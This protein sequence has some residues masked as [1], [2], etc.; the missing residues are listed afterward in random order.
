MPPSKDRTAAAPSKQ[1]A[2]RVDAAG[3]LLSVKPNSRSR[4]AAAVRREQLYAESM[5][6][7]IGGNENDINHA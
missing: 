6:L 1:A 3:R 2:P 4:A 5:G 7:T